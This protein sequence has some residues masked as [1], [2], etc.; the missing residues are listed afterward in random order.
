MKTSFYMLNL[1]VPLEIFLINTLILVNLINKQ[2]ILW[3]NSP[4]LKTMTWYML[5]TTAVDSAFKILFLWICYM[6]VQYICSKKR[7]CSFANLKKII[8]I[9]YKISALNQ[10]EY[11]QGFFFSMIDPKTKVQSSC[12]S[13]TMQGPSV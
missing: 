7:E 13:H 12:N 10:V 2:H 11:V 8:F 4:S 9:T 6:G 5:C 3:L 1:T